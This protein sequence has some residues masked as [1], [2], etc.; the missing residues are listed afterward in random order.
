MIKCIRCNSFKCPCSE[1]QYRDYD[2][3]IYNQYPSNLQY[4]LSQDEASYINRIRFLSEEEKNELIKL[5]DKYFDS[6]SLKQI[7]ELNLR[8]QE[9]IRKL[10][11]LFAEYN[12]ELNNAYEYDPS[13]YQGDI[14][15]GS[16]HKDVPLIIHTA[17]NE[18][19]ECL[20]TSE[21]DDSL[22]PLNTVYNNQEGN[23]IAVTIG[24]IEHSIVYP[25]FNEEGISPLDLDPREDFEFNEFASTYSEIGELIDNMYDL[26]DSVYLDLHKMIEKLNQIKDNTNRTYYFNFNPGWKFKDAWNAKGVYYLVISRDLDESSPSYRSYKLYDTISYGKNYY[27]EASEGYQDEPR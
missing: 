5:T 23:N 21:E 3:A 11:K 16:I 2:I 18:E 12:K 14:Y 9:D 4:Y 6:V 25:P 19:I 10:Y 24:D 7:G 20:N 1:V 17:I 15:F 13:F 8:I 22:I 27:G 26:T